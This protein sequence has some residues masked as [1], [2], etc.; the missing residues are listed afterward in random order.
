MPPVR[1]KLGNC[2]GLDFMWGKIREGWRQHCTLKAG[3]TTI[4]LWQQVFNTWN[5]GLHSLT[6]WAGED[7]GWRGWKRKEETRVFKVES[8]LHADSDSAQTF[9]PAQL[10][11]LFNTLWWTS[12]WEHFYLLWYLTKSSQW[13]EGDKVCYFKNLPIKE[14]EVPVL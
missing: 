13:R 1:A 11:N 7:V 8:V 6:H 5:C 2:S 9:G 14:Q 3:E 12:N 10:R 4:L